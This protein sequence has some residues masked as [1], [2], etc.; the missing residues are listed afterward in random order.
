MSSLLVEEAPS[1]TP[2]YTQDEIAAMVGSV[3]EVVQR[4]RKT[5]E[6]AGLIQMARGRVQIIDLDALESWSEAESIHSGPEVPSTSVLV[7]SLTQS[8]NAR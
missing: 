6:H 1:S 2:E 5:L 4:A 7:P 3:R 8:R